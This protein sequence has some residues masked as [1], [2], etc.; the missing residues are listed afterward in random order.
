MPN[1]IEKYE[2]TLRNEI[3]KLSVIATVLIL[4]FIGIIIYSFLQIKLDK[5]KKLPYIQLFATIVLLVFL[6]ISLGLQIISYAK[7]ISE[8]SYIQ[9]EGPVCIRMERQIV[10][11]GIP[12]GYNEY[13]ISFT[14][15]GQQIDLAMR[16]D[17]KLSGDIEKAYVVYSKHSNYI[18]EFVI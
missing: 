2:S 14:H 15:D 8:A 3:V 10:F 17:P 13:I 4:L 7:D 1:D 6:S 12:T 18:F 16:K 11:G 5:T 9:Y